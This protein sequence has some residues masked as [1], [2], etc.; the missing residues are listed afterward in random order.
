MVEEFG[1]DAA[2]DDLRA[3][4]ERL[5]NSFREDVSTFES[6]LEQSF[7]LYQQLTAVDLGQ[8]RIIEVVD[9]INRLI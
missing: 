2:T 9:L 4:L 7:F 8:G 3:A 6:A 5:E 1:D